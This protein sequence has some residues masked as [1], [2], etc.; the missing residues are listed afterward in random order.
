MES[1]RLSQLAV[2]ALALVLLWLL[3]RLWGGDLAAAIAALLC[4]SMPPF[5]WWSRAGANYTVPL[6]PL[7]LGMML[8]LSLWWRGRRARWLALAAFLFGAGVTTKILFIWMLIPLGATLLF[9]ARPARLLAALR[10]MR[11]ST[12]ALVIAAAA[13]ARPQVIDRSRITAH[14]FIQRRERLIEQEEL[15]LSG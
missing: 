14:R 1:L 8:A 5:I 3:A 13:A 7:A 12:L 15:W 2:G 11:L 4:A 6:L 10:A 9:G